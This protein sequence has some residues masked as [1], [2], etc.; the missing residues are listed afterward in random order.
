MVRFIL[1]TMRRIQNF[2][3]RNQLDAELREEIATHLD[4]LAK[5]SDSISAKRQMGNL[6]RWCEISREAW[7]WNWLES[8]VRDLSYGGRLSG[9]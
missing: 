5:D 4:M 7:G 3:R 2:F 1:E 8:M 9:S 6:T